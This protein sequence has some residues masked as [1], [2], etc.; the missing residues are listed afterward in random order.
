[1]GALAAAGTG[2]ESIS[3]T[4]PSTG[5][6]YYYGACVDAVADE[7]DTTNNCS[8]SV[9]VTV[10]HTQRQAQG[11][12]DLEVGLPLVSDRAPVVGATFT[13]ST[14]VTNLG[15]GSS[16]A[17]T[18]RYYLS[19]D[20]TI[21]TLDTQVGT[22]AVGPLAASGTGAESI[23]LSAPS[24]GGTYYYGACVDSVA[25]E[26]DTTNNCS[27]SVEV[28]VLHTQRQA[29]GNPNLELGTP[30]VDNDRPAMGT[31]FTLS[32]TVTN[33]GDGAAASTILRYYRSTD[34]T[35]TTADM[36]LD[37]DA[38]A[39]LGASGSSAESVTLDVPTTPPPGSYYFYGACVDSVTGE[40]DTTDNCSV[41]VMVRVS[42]PDLWTKYG[43][44]NL[45]VG[46]GGTFTK[47][48]SVE[49]AGSGTSAPTTVRFLLSEDD[50]S[51]TASDTTVAT[52]DL[53][54]V[55]PGSSSG[56]IDGH[57]PA[58]SN[59]GWYYYGVCVDPVPGETNTGNNCLEYGT[60]AVG[61]FVCQPDLVMDAPSVTDNSPST[62]G[63]FTLSATVKN[64]GCAYSVETTVRYYRSLDSTITTS[65][66]PEG[67]DDVGQ[68][69]GTGLVY[70]PEGSSQ[71]M[72]VTAPATPG[73]YYYGACVDSVARESD[74]TNNCSTSVAVTVSTTAGADL[75]VSSISVDD[76]GVGPGATFTLSG[77]VTNA[78]SVGAAAT[79]LRYY[80]ST[81][82]SISTSDTELDTDPVGA[83]AAAGTSD[84]S[85]SLTAPLDTGTYYYGACVDSVT[86][87]AVTNNNCSAAV[88][89]TVDRQP[90]LVM[91]STVSPTE[92][93]PQGFF[94]V[95]GT[96]TNEGQVDVA[97][98]LTVRFY[99]S[100]D[101]T[102]T[103]SDHNLSGAGYSY[104][105]E[106]AAGGSKTRYQSHIRAP[107][108]PG[109]Y[110]YGA[111]VNT[112]AN[113]W[114]TT[115]NC[116]NAAE[117]TV[118]VYPDLS[119]SFVSMTWQVPLVPGGKFHLSARIENEGDGEAAATTLRFYHSEDDTISPSTDTELGTVEV[120]ALAAEAIKHYRLNDLTVPSE[121]GSYYYGA[122]VDAV[123]DETDTTNN[124]T[125]ASTLVVPKPAP[126]LAL[127]TMSVSD[128]SRDPG[129]TFTLSV[130]VFNHGALEAA[131]TTLR[132]YRT[133]VSPWI[134]DP[135]TDTAVGTDAVEALAS[136]AQSEES[137]ELTA[138]SIPDDYYYYACVDSVTDETETRD[139]CPSQAERVTV[140][141]PNLQ[142]GTP[143]VD[144]ATLDTG[145]AFTLS[146]T[147]TNAGTEGAAATTLRYYRSTDSTISTSDTEVGT[148][149]V[150]ALAAGGTSAESID[151]TAPSTKGTY[152]YGACVD[153]VADESP[154]TDNCSSS[155]KVTAGL[156]PDLEVGTPSVDDD[157]ATLG[158]GEAFTLSA[159][160]S[161]SGDMESPATTLRWYRSADST[162]SSTDT[163]VGSDSIGALAASG[164]SDQSID[165]TAPSTAGT[166]YY[167]ACVD[168][169][170]DE[171]DTTDN[172]SVSV[173]LV[174]E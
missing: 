169:V 99:R 157:D 108:T 92:V 48:T 122:C 17:T 10:L 151:L 124:C 139:N 164:T 170:T 105:N 52:V 56:R 173:T 168:S 32:V 94:R 75:V 163:E 23:S 123:A 147:V 2:F 89:V 30:S 98:R 127:L 82:A 61:E 104:G 155:V 96:L 47:W 148:D 131:A 120:D 18:L 73:T 109:T 135:S 70:D 16:A 71:S 62:Y 107:S 125:E 1:M 133:T 115:N 112:V 117:L 138:P 46:L 57:I 7:S 141:A 39:G 143:T 167:G 27:A 150:G 83:L 28:T 44:G 126:N 12:P 15:D 20:A 74:T 146:A 5:G 60:V 40:S 137:I 156:Y 90:D 85:V 79:T 50:K 42:K 132:Y 153:S 171:S 113:E 114:S 55:F 162:I 80:R 8:A 6:P 121:A 65:D 66:T 154:T 144:D 119:L 3:L 100:D 161:N 77:T 64:S 29:Q 134:L 21:T 166:Y 68:L 84:Q 101:A 128:N 49:N 34:E 165:L 38:V 54:S 24:A 53:S 149:D 160:V 158:T 102:I 33:A 152:Y 106:L 4:A 159:T 140:T 45:R 103:T 11:S 69:A 25:D 97:A 86:D 72:V 81:D 76:A 116:S 26:S 91:S 95:N 130:T 87:E 58:P 145:A 118:A 110:Y 51:V 9:E 37:T 111:C 174:V 88:K 43:G 13:L 31:T 14:T 78:G 129:E 142:V 41:S 93:S 22:D 172:C 59:P 136:A 35:I 67:T 19:A 63:R 36:E